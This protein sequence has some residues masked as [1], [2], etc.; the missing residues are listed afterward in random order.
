MPDRKLIKLVK[1]L[2]PH[3]NR[4]IAERLRVSEDVNKL[5]AFILSPAFK[6]VDKDEQSLLN[7]QLE[8]MATHL[9]ILDLRVAKY[10]EAKRYRCVTEI[11][12][13]PMT[14]KAYHNL[15]G[16]DDPDNDDEGFFIEHLEGGEKNH[17]DFAG[18]ITWVT[19]GIFER[20]YQEIR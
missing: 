3:Q 11:M 6:N 18:Y 13:R 10:V 14:R 7:Q 12:A 20:S 1:E 16:F 9:R 19:K 17:S 5:E 2:A 4:V 8:A 15:R